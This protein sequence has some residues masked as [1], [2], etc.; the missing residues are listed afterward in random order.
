MNRAISTIKY[1]KMLENSSRDLIPL[2]KKQL[3]IYCMLSIALYRF[4]L[5]YYNKAPLDYSLRV[6]RKCSKEQPY[7]SPVLF[8]HPPQC[9]LKPFQ[10]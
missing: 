10:I 8:E 4:Q 9:I 1:M 5:W 2:Q 6:L 3:Y 7:G